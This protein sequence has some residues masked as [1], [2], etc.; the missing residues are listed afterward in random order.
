MSSTKDYMVEI[1][2]VE[3]DK[4]SKTR[5]IHWKVDIAIWTVLV[6]A[7]YGQST[8]K[9]TL[10]EAG[11]NMKFWIC[12]AVL[13]AHIAFVIKIHRSI[14]RSLARMNAMATHLLE[15][16]DAAEFKWIDIGKSKIKTGLTWE[17]L[18]VLITLILLMVF[19]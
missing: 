6:V 4:Y 5:E 18:Q 1:Y 11:S 14:N 13:L 2:K 3:A 10:E 8:Q 12:F 9:F 16:P 17:L 19:Y 15:S 7:I